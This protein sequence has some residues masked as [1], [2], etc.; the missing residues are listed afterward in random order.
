M[1]TA[2][3]RIIA[4]QAGMVARRQLTAH[5]IGWDHVHHQVVAGRWVERTERVISTTTG[6]LSGEQRLWLAVLH[7]GPRS[8]LGGLTAAGVHGLAGWERDDV[9]VMVDDELS[10]EP[11]EG[12]QFF[13]SR[14]P[15]DLLRSPRPGVPRARLEP[16]VLLWAAYDA[17]TRAAHGVIAAVVQQRLTTPERMIEWVDRLHPLRR[18]KPFKHT[19]SDVAGGAHSASELDIRRMCRRFQLRPPNRQPRRTDR[20][21]KRR[22]T[23]AEWDLPDGSVLVLEVD[24]GHHVEVR[25]WHD[26]LKRAR[27]LT[28]RNRTVL[29]CSSYELRHE[30][31]EVAADLIALGVPG[32]VPEDA[33]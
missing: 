15:L 17:Q 23:D 9:T 1:R 24:G 27:R 10:F 22:W 29:R 5:G 4:A 30:T 6:P 33:A 31:E 14:R 19:L 20:T 32:R 2:A 11:V 16:A 8:M 7:A 18:A 25:Q 13:R 28:A 26:D 12:V 21:G 3:R